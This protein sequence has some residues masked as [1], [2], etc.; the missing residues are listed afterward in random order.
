MI[1]EELALQTLTTDSAYCLAFGAGTVVLSPKIARLVSLP[2]PLVAAT[3]ASSVA[4]GAWVGLA[5]GG[6]DWRTAAK[7]AAGA[8]T[9]G[10]AA[11]GALAV[12]RP[13]RGSRIAVAAVAVPV[14]AFA[15]AQI[16]A[17][18]WDRKAH[19]GTEPLPMEPDD[20]AG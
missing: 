6:G 16:A 13:T 12:T 19:I 5:A 4:W 1:P 14:A 11:L 20:L 9:L 3:G 10:A 17:L 2:T 8:N 7:V 15:G 18:V